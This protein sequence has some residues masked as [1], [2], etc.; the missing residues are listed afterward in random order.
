M[1][2]SPQ[3]GLAVVAVNYNAGEYLSRCI[4]SVLGA[5]AGIDLLVVVVDNAS[6][7][8]SA[9]AAKA[10]YPEIL[11]L[12]NPDNRG[13]SAA[14]NQGIR[15]TSAPFVLVLNPD[16]EIWSGPLAGLVKVAQDRPTVGAVGPVIR[17]ADGTMYESGRAFPGI[18]RALGHAFIGP[19]APANPFTRAYRQSGWDRTAEREVDWVSGA[20]ILLRRRA[21]E[22]VGLFD[23][24]FFL[25]G[26][27]LDMCTR[28]RR[29][30]WTVLFSPEVEVLHEGAV[31][32]G[33][34]RRM[35][36]MHSRSIYR[37]FAKHRAAGWRRILRP[38]AW[39]AL[40]ARAEVVSLRDRFAR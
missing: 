9:R 30:G 12:E 24:G 23:E 1:E 22:E 15:A 37:Y 29:A 40:S 25:Y 33:R 19:F 6:G 14:W 3:P 31:S 5:A 20:C 11:L 10:A 34:S 39:I 4:G 38:F 35:H 36:R 27:E 21:L 28:L 17:N 18:G 13:L 16:A 26:E 2:G 8:G 7:D 32:T